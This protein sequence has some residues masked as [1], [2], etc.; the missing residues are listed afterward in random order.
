MSIQYTSI[1]LPLYFHYTSLY[2]QA[3]CEGLCV[4]DESPAEPVPSAAETYEEA[5]GKVRGHVG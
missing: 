4:Q 1:I 5:D 3:V 2:S